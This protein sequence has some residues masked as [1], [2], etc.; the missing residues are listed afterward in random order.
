MPSTFA[1]A[2]RFEGG[3]AGSFVLTTGEKLDLQVT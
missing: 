2:Q 1:D 3:L